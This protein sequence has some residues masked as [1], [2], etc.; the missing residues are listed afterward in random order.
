MPDIATT[1]A[2]PLLA[3]AAEPQGLGG[4]L[5]I[6]LVVSI[7]GGALLAWFLLRGYANGGEDPAAAAKDRRTAAAR[8]ENDPGDANA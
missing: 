3:A 4:P 2:T 7:L 6:V 8:T 5:R 1:V